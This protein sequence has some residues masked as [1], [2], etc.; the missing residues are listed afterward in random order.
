MR[1]VRGG[2]ALVAGTGRWGGAS[3]ILLAVTGLLL[4]AQLLSPDLVLWT[5]AHVRGTS[6]AGQVSFRYRGAG[7]AAAARPAPADP[8]RPVPVAVFF[9]PAHPDQAVLDNGWNRAVDAAVLLGPLLAAGA[10]LARGLQVRRRRRRRGPQGSWM[11]LY[12]DRA[13]AEVPRPPVARG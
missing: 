12:L 13:R 7:Y 5:G 8:V 4:A 11:A 9:D 3:A 6:Q 10:A 2:R 1:A